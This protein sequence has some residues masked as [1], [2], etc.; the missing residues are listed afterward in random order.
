MSS[1]LEGS[2]LVR[3]ILRPVWSIF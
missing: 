2:L 1:G 3:E